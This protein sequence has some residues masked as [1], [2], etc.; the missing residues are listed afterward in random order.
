MKTIYLD[1]NIIG[2]LKSKSIEND[3]IIKLLRTKYQCVVSRETLEEICNSPIEYHQAHMNVIAE[4]NTKLIVQLR[5]PP[6]FH[7]SDRYRLDTGDLS[8]LLPE[9]LA[10]KDSYD[11]STQLMN[12]TLHDLVKYHGGSPELNQLEISKI[13]TSEFSDCMSQL[14]STIN[15]LG[16]DSYQT[17]KMQSDIFDMEMSFINSQEETVRLYTE[18]ETLYTQNPKSDFREHIDT[19][20]LQLS[21][22]NGPNIIHQICS[23]LKSLD[24]YLEKSSEEI[25]GISQNYLYPGEVLT[26]SEQIIAI[27]NML[28]SLNYRSDR[29]LHKEQ[30]LKSF[31]KDQVHCMYGSCC[32]YI[33]AIDVGLRY[34]AIAIYEYLDMQT[35]VISF[36]ELTDMLDARC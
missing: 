21:N 2:T 30:K 9:I 20:A 1:T 33:C 12:T 28:D 16:L 15:N 6:L 7:P 32:D 27:Y 13:K 35:E 5:D 17:D 4:L 29:K 25:L 24:I 11:L 26:L 8:L 10:K 14:S 31:M 19:I 23:R 3:R 34:K 18:H 22:I 36:D